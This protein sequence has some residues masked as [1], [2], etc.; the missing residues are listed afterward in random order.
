MSSASLNE[1]LSHLRANPQMRHDFIRALVALEPA[2]QKGSRLNIREKITGPFVDALYQ[3]GEILAAWSN[4]GVLQA[5]IEISGPGK[6]E[7]SATEGTE[8]PIAGES[9]SPE[10]A[11]ESRTGALTLG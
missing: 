7:G 10:S 3:H 5:K 6:P 1:S 4:T 2:L 9:S 8:P 11:R